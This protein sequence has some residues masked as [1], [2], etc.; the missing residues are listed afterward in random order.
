MRLLG[1]DFGSKRIGI[2]VAESDPRAISL[3]P[4]LTPA[5]ALKKDAVALVAFAKKEQADKI[6]LGLP[7][8]SEGED[9]RMARVCR[10]LA[11]HISGLGVSVELVDESLTSVGAEDHLREMGLKA[12]ERKKLRDGEAAARIIERYL[13]GGAHD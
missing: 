5:G 6:I 8:N 1:V 9:Q 3:R 4:A 13:D 2:A 7:E 11:D 10:M 12:S